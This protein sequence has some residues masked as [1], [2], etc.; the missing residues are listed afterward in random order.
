MIDWSMLRVVK[1]SVRRPAKREAIQFSYS[2]DLEAAR[3]RNEILK[4]FRREPHSA[5]PDTPTGSWAN[6]RRKTAATPLRPI[7]IG[8]GPAAYFAAACCQML[9]APCCGSVA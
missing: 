7:V 4:R 5:S 9:I 3:S 2:L 1:R 8:A 6:A